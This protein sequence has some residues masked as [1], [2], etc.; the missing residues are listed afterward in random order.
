MSIQ[1]ILLGAGG[2]TKLYRE[3]LFNSLLFEGNGST[4]RGINMG[5][6]LAGAGGMVWTKDIDD[7]SGDDGG[8][9]VYN[10][11]RGAGKMIDLNDNDSEVTTSDGITA[12]TS[13]GYTTSNKQGC[14]GNNKRIMSYAFRKEANFMDIVEV[15]TN[16]ETAFMVNH[17]LGAKP[18]FIMMRNTGAA[19]WF[20]WHK[21]IAQTSGNNT[22]TSD[23]LHFKLS[24]SGGNSEVSSDDHYEVGRSASATQVRVPTGSDL[25][26]GNGKIIIIVFA[27]H[28]G[29]TDHPAGAFG[30]GGNA[31]IIKCGYYVGNNDNGTGGPDIDLGW[32][33]EFLMIGRMNGTYTGSNNIFCQTRG[34]YN[35]FTEYMTYAIRLDGSYTGQQ[36]WS[37]A[38]PAPMHNG[39][40]ARG[41]GDSINSNQNNGGTN[42]YWYLAI[43]RADGVVSKGIGGSSQRADYSRYTQSSEPVVTENFRIDATLYRKPTASHD[44]WAACR[45]GGASFVETNKFNNEMEES[46]LSFESGTQNQAHKGNVTSGGDT[47]FMNWTRCDTFDCFN[48]KGSGSD[49]RVVTHNMGLAPE[50]IWIKGLNTNG[51]DTNHNDN[52]ANEHY[53]W[54]CWHEGL[55]GGG[56]SAIGRLFQ[57]NTQNAPETNSNIFK[58]IPT[59][60]GFTVGT[61]GRINESGTIY[62]C[63]LFA[64]KAGISKVGHFNSQGSGWIDIDL[65]FNPRTLFIMKDSDG[66]RYMQHTTQSPAWNSDES[67]NKA[68]MLNMQRDLTA[69]DG[70]RTM[71]NGFQKEA[72]S[73]SENW[74]YY[75]H[76]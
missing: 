23:E 66:W 31:D 20:C 4:S 21:D 2:A 7:T 15:S 25:N 56:N 72:S 16:N 18:G 53:G 70:T 71:S 73:G 68:W 13:S 36:R 57:M 6:D 28:E 52:T 42:K 47:Y 46:D 62:N 54:A 27:S 45:V 49:N 5:V 51:A 60:T 65:G 39:F 37:Y 1:Q 40:K 67:D 8:V 35:V 55:N 34:M 61:H 64:S 41:T 12:F 74:L 48:Y 50:M 10:T 14:N 32:D 75:A 9:H 22:G 63:W 17:S 26:Y 29:S 38:G 43:R 33:P 11:V 44:T 59:A 19:H 58:S 69:W 30:G 76:A 24:M 3:D